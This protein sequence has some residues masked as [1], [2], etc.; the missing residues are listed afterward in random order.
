MSHQ[1]TEI[2][3]M[4]W[5][6][7]ANKLA[8]Q[9]RRVKI[10]IQ[11]REKTVMQIN[12]SLVKMLQN[13]HVYLNNPKL[14]LGQKTSLGSCQGQNWLYRIPAP[15]SSVLESIMDHMLQDVLK[16]TDNKILI[17]HSICINSNTKKYV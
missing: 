7:Q 8:R 17:V 6:M 2:S 5:I 4:S 12:T 16:F 11:M 9:D 3:L 15:H 14:G 1:V 10:L 13:G